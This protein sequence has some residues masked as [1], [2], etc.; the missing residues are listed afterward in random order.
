M[1]EPGKVLKVKAAHSTVDSHPM[2]IWSV[3]PR[4]LDRQALIAGFPF[5]SDHVVR[6]QP[7]DATS[8]SVSWD[9]K[10]SVRGRKLTMQAKNDN[11]DYDSF[12]NPIE[13]PHEGFGAVG[14]YCEPGTVIG[15]SN[16]LVEK[17]GEALLEECAT[18][19]R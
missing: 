1:N 2:R 12:G 6:P 4:Y 9:L 19:E 17:G 14:F 3:H 13:L 15:V 10:F 18:W 7:G 8:Y 5:T 11:G 16:V